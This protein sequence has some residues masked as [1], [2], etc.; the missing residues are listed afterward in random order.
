MEM[1]LGQLNG[2]LAATVRADI[3]ATARAAIAVRTA[4]SDE[5]TWKA[6]MKEWTGG[7]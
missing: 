2:F 6:K 7:E 3:E 5:K 4:R 1:T